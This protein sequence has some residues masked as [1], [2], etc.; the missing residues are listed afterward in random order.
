MP[1]LIDVHSHLGQ[2]ASSRMSADGEQLCRLFR[3]AGIT[4][5]VAFSIEA[6]HGG[7]DLGNQYTLAE[8]EKH[9]ML[10]AMV[11]LHPQHPASSARWVAQAASNL[12]IV[13]AKL[14]PVLGNF[15]ILS[16]SVL[17]LM[18]EMV[19]PSG[20]TVLSHTGNE[21]P[22]VPIGRFLQLAARFPG[23]NFI[24]AHLGVGILGSGGAA[25]DAWKTAGPLPNV[26]FD[27]G[28]LRSFSSGAVESLLEAVGPDRIC[29]GTDAP[30]YVPDC[31]VR[32]L[33][34]L[35]LPAG[36][37]EQIAW[38]NALAAI[39]RLAGRVVV[40]GAEAR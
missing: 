12:K 30:L 9:D 19:G 21:S 40:A 1:A 14:H 27:M 7:I 23:I 28:T 3:R 36:V 11:V 4:H 8:V 33:E 31:F 22:N 39:P 37:H 25:I 2:F 6:C 20:L 34:A 18:E 16:N 26:W 24:A 38:R 15:D 5:G 29:F 13:G 10:S 35:S 17:R 32:L